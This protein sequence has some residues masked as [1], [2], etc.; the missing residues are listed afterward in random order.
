MQI[1]IVDD[2]MS[3][4]HV[5]LGE[6]MYERNVEYK[7]FQDD[8]REIF[9]YCRD[10]RIDAAFLDV[11][12]PRVNGFDLARELCEMQPWIKFVFITGL[13]LTEKDLSDDL[14]EHTLGFIYKPYDRE[15]L[16]GYLDEISEG[17]FRLE[18]RMFDSF[19]C[20]LHGRRVEFSS[21]KSKEL[22]ALLL[23]YNGKS[24]TMA[25]A[26]S[27]MWPDH[28]PVKAKGL[29]RDAVWRLR[30]TLQRINFE[31]VVFSRAELV[32]NKENIDCDFWD[33]LEGKNGDYRGE[34][35]KS[36]DWSLEFLGYIDKMPR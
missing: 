4:L 8:V 36:Y 33:F 22:F 9:A 2:E 21:L 3:A 12:M 6:I 10:H 11:K 31:C 27:K 15:E 1:V 16:R 14:K 32:L 20:F 26:I 28:D 18:A 34:L 17:S 29:Y 25:D 5:F 35:L 13:S 30:K 23:Y 19:D 7:F 24:L